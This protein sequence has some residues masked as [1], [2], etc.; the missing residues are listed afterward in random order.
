MAQEKQSGGL[1][2]NFSLD[3][4][5]EL[6]GIKINDE[7]PDEKLVKS[8]KK[9]DDFDDDDDDTEVTNLE[10]EKR[11]DKAKKKEK[12]KEDEDEE[13]ELFEDEDDNEDRKTKTKKEVTTSEKNKADKDSSKGKD[14]NNED[15]D[16]NEN[17]EVDEDFFTNLTLDLKEKGV[18]TNVEIPKD[19]K[20]TEE[21]FFE[22]QDEEIEK[23]VEETFEAMFEEI[24]EEGKDFLNYIKD[25]GNVRTYL[26][27]VSSAFNLDELDIENQNQVNKTLRYYLAAYEKLEDEE[28]EDK[29]KWLEESGKNK[30][31]ATKYFKH[32]KA[33]ENERKT[34]LIE[35]QRLAAD[36]KVENTKNFNKAI[37]EVLSETE[38]VG[39]FIFTKA[40]Q[41]ELDS[42]IT[43]PVVKVGK[44]KYLPEF[45]IELSRIL[46]AKTKEDKQHLLILAKLA[47]EKFKL[48]D[49]ETNTT[50]KVVSKVKSKLAESK[51]IM[52]SSSSGG[53][54]SRKSLA[55]YIN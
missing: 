14:D 55:D 15:D 48:T 41:K 34:A 30:N 19:T 43:K 2:E 54:S 7:T 39:S 10:E 23:R 22:L 44:N 8:V 28:L 49:L 27:Q 31:Y 32:I 20:I 46:Q 11:K 3:D 38:S 4:G 13:I 1:L 25:G 40:D 42:Y 9:N 12:V 29:I 35:A 53:N 50:T 37:K 18:F 51:N 16:N 24:G 26:T 5:E 47:K 36:R 21:K 6:F 52:K 33:D 45:Q 17:E